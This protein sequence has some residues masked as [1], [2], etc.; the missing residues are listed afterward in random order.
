MGDA[1]QEDFS[2]DDDVIAVGGARGTICDIRTMANG[3]P[4]YGVQDLT[5][6]VRYYV[7]DGLKRFL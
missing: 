1:A 4:V 5:G 6:A 3:V 7:A 2:I